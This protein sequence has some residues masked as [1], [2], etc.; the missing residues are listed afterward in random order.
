MCE[1]TRPAKAEQRAPSQRIPCSFAATKRAGS[2]SRS[3]SLSVENRGQSGEYEQQAPQVWQSKSLSD[4]MRHFL[5]QARKVRKV[6]VIRPAQRPVTEK[7]KAAVAIT[8]AIVLKDQTG[9]MTDE[10][11]SR[12]LRLKRFKYQSTRTFS[13]LDLPVL[14]SWPTS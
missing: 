12:S 1:P 11:K 6:S 3:A 5:A 14:R 7:Q 8:A 10:P 2:K 4:V 13:A 9:I